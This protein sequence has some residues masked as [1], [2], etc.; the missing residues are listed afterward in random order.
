MFGGFWRKVFMAIERK[1]KHSRKID[2]PL[3]PKTSE[4]ERE[5]SQ[6]NKE[7]MRA[8]LEGSSET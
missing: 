7:R 4:K 5:L 8:L 6:N 3:R 2:H 1:I